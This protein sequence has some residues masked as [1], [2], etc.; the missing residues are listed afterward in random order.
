[1][2]NN[3][4]DAL[5]PVTAMYGKAPIS[6]FGPLALKAV[7]QTMVDDG[8]SRK[9]VNSRIN[10]VRRM[11]KWGVE[12]QL[13]DASLLHALQ[14]VAPLKQGLNRMLARHQ[15]SCLYRMP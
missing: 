4:K 15:V 3:I 11:F 1:M 8:L 10:R 6:E 2:S 5:R 12:N 7:R 13:V 14:A 9:V